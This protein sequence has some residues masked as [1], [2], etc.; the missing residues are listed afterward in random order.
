MAEEED[1]E[2]DDTLVGATAESSPHP[3]MRGLFGHDSC[4]ERL[5]NQARINDLGSSNCYGRKK[6]IHA[7]YEQVMEGLPTV[8]A[9]KD[10]VLR[11][12]YRLLLSL[13]K[14][15]RRRR[16]GE[17]GMHRAKHKARDAALAVLDR[18]EYELRQ[19]RAVCVVSELEGCCCFQTGQH[20]EHV[21]F[22]S[23]VR[24]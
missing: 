9:E 10:Y 4:K 1:T 18:L 22:I 16:K 20:D 5:R 13:F 2:E 21:T 3:S 24:Q 12:N 23:A 8:S 15:S 19:Q 11:I 6:D 14:T 17:K 7:K